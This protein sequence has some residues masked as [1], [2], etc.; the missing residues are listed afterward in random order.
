[1]VTRSE[2]SHENVVF[3]D[4]LCVLCSATVSLLIKIDLRR[5]LRYSSLNGEFMRSLGDPG[6]PGLNPSVVFWSMGK[7]Y[8]RS[9]AGI[10]ILGQLGGAYRILGAALSVIPRFVLDALYDLIARNRYRLFGKRK[11][12]F[13]PSP[14]KLTLFI[15]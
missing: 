9:S 1:M 13:I 5:R 8:T 3:F 15:P 14:E 6:N 7:F 2:S 12:C 11:T 10:Q 4:D